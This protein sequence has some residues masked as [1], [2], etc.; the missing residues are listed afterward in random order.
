MHS[1]HMHWKFI[2]I[3]FIGRIG[4]IMA[5]EKWLNALHEHMTPT[6]LKS[7]RSKEIVYG[8]I[9]QC[10]LNGSMQN[11]RRKNVAPHTRIPL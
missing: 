6:K 9:E 10:Q 4:I 2:W 1:K 8:S 11:V 3:R 5:E 7:V